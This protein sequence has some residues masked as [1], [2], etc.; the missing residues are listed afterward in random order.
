MAV[1][2]VTSGTRSATVTTEHFES[3][4]N[5][6]GSF[7]FYVDLS[8]MAAGDVVELRAYKMAVT[9]GTS[10]VVEY[11][12]FEGVQPA[13][14]YVKKLGPI[15]NTLTDSNAT[16]FSIKQTFGSSIDA[17]WAVLN[18]EDATTAPADSAGTT[19]LLSRLSSTRAGYLDNLSAGAVAT[20]AKLLSYFQ[21]AL[22]KDVTVDADIGGNYDDATDSQEAIRDRGDSAWT[23][24]TGFS[25]HSAADVWAVGT[26][27]LTSFGT[28]VADVASAVWAAGSR[29]LTAFGFSVTVGTNSDKTGYALTSAYD[30]AKTAA[31]QAS[32]DDLPTNAELATALGTADDAV[33]SA[34]AALNNLS[35]AGAQAA[36]AAALTAYGAATGA[37]V[38]TA[39][40]NADKILGRNIAGGSDGGRDVTS[41][42][43]AV[44]NKVTVDATTITVYQEDDT[45]SAWTGTATR[46]EGLDPLE[47][48]DPG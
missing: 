17:P 30:A 27:T 23:T 39:A 33:L 38:P 35:S 3:S 14:D 48:V 16:R 13:D 32:V 24:A 21:S 26:R 47:T 40:Q 19:T 9:G 8:D 25:T 12:R 34:I 28:L 36:A 6:A 42:L 10:R 31:T 2:L 11:Q 37:Q 41:A 29:T 46:T 45:T 1:T 4:P 7:V 43:R 44:R 22:R 15:P 20:A 18:T 5:V